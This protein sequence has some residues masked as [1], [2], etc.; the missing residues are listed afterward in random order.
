MVLWKLS[1]LLFHHTHATTRQ[2]EKWNTINQSDKTRGPP[3]ICIFTQRIEIGL[4]NVHD[5]YCVRSFRI[6]DV[7]SYESD[8]ARP[9][10]HSRGR[11]S[12]RTCHIIHTFVEFGNS[13]YFVR[14]TK[15]ES[16]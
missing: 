7:D 1:S 4:Y 2:P 6:P 14:H 9:P 16:E 11:R 3:S 15:R 12:C 8:K 13:N 10:V 5:K